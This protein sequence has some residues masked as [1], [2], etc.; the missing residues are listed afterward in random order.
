M[1]REHYTTVKYEDVLLRVHPMSVR[2]FIRDRKNARYDSYTTV[3]AGEY[4][5]KRVRSRSPDRK[6]CICRILNGRFRRGKKQK[7]TGRKREG[8]EKKK[9]RSKFYTPRRV[10]VSEDIHG[11]RRFALPGH[12]SAKDCRRYFVGKVRNV[13]IKQKRLL[14]ALTTAFLGE[15]N[16]DAEKNGTAAKNAIEK[17]RF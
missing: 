5:I 6:S 14:T 3:T 17:F 4:G 8:G 15:E 11:R 9:P 16:T 1:Y 7:K 10:V 2:V 12:R 13:R